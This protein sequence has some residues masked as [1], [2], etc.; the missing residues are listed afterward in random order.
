MIQY[1]TW[2]HQHFQ[3]KYA[4]FKI[5]PPPQELPLMAE[6]LD[7]R[8]RGRALAFRERG[9]EVTVAYLNHGVV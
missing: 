7:K 3:D 5:L 1:F 9:R 6:K 4:T 8:I 2:Y